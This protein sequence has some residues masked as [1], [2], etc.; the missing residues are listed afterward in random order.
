MNKCQTGWY[1]IDPNLGMP[2]D[3]IYVFCNMTGSGETCVYPDLQ[4]SKMPNI[5]WRKEG[6]KEDWYS[7]MRGASKVTY[8]TVG[9][10][11]MTFLRLLSQKAY[12]NFTFTCVNSVSWYNQRTFNYDQVS[13][14]CVVTIRNLDLNSI[15]T[16]R[17]SSC[18]AITNRNSAPKESDPTLFLTDAKYRFS[19]IFL[20]Y[21][22]R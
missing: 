3:A 1:W 19:H 17:P 21:P 8:E 7:N 14:Y 16:N 6:G 22:V 18:W 11:Q 15:V 10:V 9:V 5:P 12:Q 4:S 20:N 13:I 2:D